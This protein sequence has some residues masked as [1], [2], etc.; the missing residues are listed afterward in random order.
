MVAE[1]SGCGMGRQ[2]GLDFNGKLFY[3]FCFFFYLET[4]DSNIYLYGC[5]LKMHE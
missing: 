2:G 3:V 4:R 5:G 1:G